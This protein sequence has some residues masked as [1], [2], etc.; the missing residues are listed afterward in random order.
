MAASTP[1]RTTTA[2]P[3]WTWEAWV[4]GTEEWYQRV[5]WM[6]HVLG[7]PVATVTDEIAAVGGG[8][9]AK[10]DETA[11]AGKNAA[12]WAQKKARDAMLLNIAA[13]AAAV[14]LVLVAGGVGLALWSKLS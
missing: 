3:V 5:G 13:G 7:G 9:A 12:E 14:S 2:E 4:P 10:E 8:L 6:G 11:E 1:T